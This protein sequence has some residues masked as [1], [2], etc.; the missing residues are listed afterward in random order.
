MN[1]KQYLIIGAS[2]EAGQSAVEAIRNLNNQAFIVGTTTQKVNV[3]GIDLTLFEI[4]AEENIDKYVQSAL[5]HAKCSPKFEALIYTPALGEVGIPIASI[6]L[7]SYKQALGIS[8]D[9]ML[10]LEK[11]L[12]P[13]L[14]IGYSAYY[15]LDHT[16]SFYGSMGHV[17]RCME[18]WALQ[19]PTN[20]RII[21]AGT[22]FSKSVRGISLVLQRLI[23][24]T[25][26][27]D[28]LKLKNAYEGSGKKFPEFFLEYAWIHEKE[29]FSSRFPNVPYRP[30]SR[31]DL[32][33]GLQIALESK[34]P[35][36]SVLGDWT[37]EESFMPELPSWFPDK[38]D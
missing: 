5:D 12:K 20:R 23:K 19:S 6:S 8:F 33:R 30:T 14:T 11:H 29:G 36:V 24:K 35:I 18:E 2:G 26:D 34:S 37:W 28:I 16:K 25:D 17:K 1:Q 31:A 3:P 13:K 32:S 4:Q 21:R 9:P 22:F 38:L 15:W 27:P 10:A 7:T